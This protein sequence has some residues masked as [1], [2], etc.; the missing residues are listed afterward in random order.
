[1]TRRYEGRA[2]PRPDDEV[3]DQ[4]LAFDLGTLGRRGMLRAL[5]LGAVALGAAACGSG[6]PG[7]AAT[8][9]PDPATG[10]TEIPDETGGPYPA[11][12]TNGANVLTETGV[13]RSDI[14]SSFGTSTTT[15]PG[16]PTTLELTVLDVARGGAPFAG[17][18]VYV[19]HCDRSGDYSMYSDAIRTENYLRGVQIADA[20][21]VV[22]FTSVFPA[23][24][25]GRWPHVHFEVYPDQAG[26]TDHGTCLAT[27]QIALPKPTCDAVYATAGY[28]SSIGNLA[29]VSLTDDN[30]FG[31][32]GGAH[33]LAA[34]TG[35]VTAGFAVGL[36]VPVD[37]RTAPSAG[38]PP[39]GGG[40][41]GG[42]GGPPRR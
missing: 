10:L 34:V 39:A 8:A 4:G 6:A 30:V 17:T 14:R 42:P 25:S 7:T 24:Y 22:R 35:D 31:D 15:A 37:T 13:V 18:A 5:G 21:G 38:A 23:C 20:R 19:W 11:D 16:V 40:G 3:V 41:P 2:L 1:M 32:D 9:T 27:S 33:Q 36:T 28:E 12:G 29:D 26:I